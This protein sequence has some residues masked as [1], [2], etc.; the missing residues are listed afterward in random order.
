VSYD[1]VM[2]AVTDLVQAL[3]QLIE[4]TQRNMGAVIHAS[5]GMLPELTLSYKKTIYHA[6]QEGLTNGIRHGESKEFYFTLEYVKSMIKMKLKDCGIGASEIHLGF[7]LTAMR[8]R[9]E[10][11]GGQFVI[12]SEPDQGC[13]LRIELPYSMRDT[14]GLDAYD[15]NIDRR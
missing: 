1:K 11:L 5:I 13:L 4:E 3:H 9:V 6:L 10:Q 8:E 15:S 14:G 2:T 7:G 12:D